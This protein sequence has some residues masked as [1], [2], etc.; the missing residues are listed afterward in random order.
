[1]TWYF[2]DCNSDYYYS[3]SNQSSF[4]GSLVE[5]NVYAITTTDL[6][7]ICTTA[8]NLDS[9][10][11][12]L[13]NTETIQDI[14]L[15]DGDCTTCNNIYGLGVTPTPTPTM[16]NTPGSSPTPTKT[17]TPSPTPTYTP[18][19]TV[20]QTPTQTPTITATP[21]QTATNT[22]TPSITPTYTPTPSI[23]STPF[24]TQTAPVYPVVTG[25]TEVL[26]ILTILP[27][28]VTCYPISPSFYGGSDGS[29]TLGINGGTP[30]Y[31]IRWSTGAQGV[32]LTN[33]SAG[34]YSAQVSDYY[35]D[36]T[37]SI[38]C[39][40]EQV[41]PTPTQ[42]LTPTI[43]PT[44]SSYIPKFCLSFFY[45]GDYYYVNFEFNGSTTYPMDLKWI[46]TTT[47]L[48]TSQVSITFNSDNS[49]WS[50]SSFYPDLI[51][52]EDFDQIQIK[53]SAQGGN[54]YTTPTN[55]SWIA[56]GIIVDDLVVNDNYPYGKVC[57]DSYDI[58]ITKVETFPSCS[59][60]DNGKITI[61]TNNVVGT[62]EYSINSLDGPWQTSNP[63]FLNV[64]PGT[65][66]VAARLVSNTDSYEIYDGAVVSTV[67][68]PSLQTNIVGRDVFVRGKVGM[69]GIETVKNYTFQIGNELFNSTLSSVNVTFSISTVLKVNTE[70]GSYNPYLLISKPVVQ[71]GDGSLLNPIDDS[72]Y[73]MT[74]DTGCDGFDNKLTSYTETIQ[75]YKYNTDVSV[76]D[77][78]SGSF[79]LTWL[80]PVI[81]NYS[82]EN[83]KCFIKNE[84][85]FQV[86]ILNVSYPST[87]RPDNIN[88][89]PFRFTGN[90]YTG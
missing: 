55:L 9:T 43:T 76:S 83:Y 7:V 11:T 77:I 84:W 52:A 82:F 36:F 45:Y 3:F 64:T 61:Y 15:I 13:I 30:P 80:Q 19:P 66:S 12:Y 49:I 70:V 51:P 22:P 54:S 38:N 32:Q 6:V 58:K 18:T 56:L 27:L 47:N 25:N 74:I 28:T 21:T 59:N 89:S 20:S 42:T 46:S 71:L 90:Y 40:V 65:Y 57:D 41:T 48:T 31:N 35:N 62:L 24:P 67:Q 50:T 86:Q 87:C 69:S 33:L 63:I 53:F 2:K 5:G 8:Q 4:E 81:D 39:T 60:T 75:T 26:S 23:T 72:W 78:I 34:T 79:N 73:Q 85:D 17:A 88:N 29:I 68:S 37:T 10:P 14:I 1:M 16:T 44:P